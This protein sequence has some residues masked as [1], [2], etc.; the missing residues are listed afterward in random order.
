MPRLHLND[1]RSSSRRRTAKKSRSKMPSKGF[2]AND[3]NQR[4][5]PKPAVESDVK[6]SSTK[7][8]V[9]ILRS[10]RFGIGMQRQEKTEQ[11]G[12]D[13][14]Y[15][16]A[17]KQ[18]SLQENTNDGNDSVHSDSSVDEIN[19]RQPSSQKRN[20][21]NKKKESELAALKNQYET[22]IATMK[23]PN[24]LFSTA[25]QN[26]DDD[27]STGSQNISW[28]KKSALG[29]AHLSAKPGLLSPSEMSRVSTIPPTP[30]STKSNNPVPTPFSEIATTKLH[31]TID[32]TET[33]SQHEIVNEA[34][35]ED[36]V[37]VGATESSTD[38]I[39]ANDNDDLFPGEVDDNGSE[40]ETHRSVS[41]DHAGTLL[42]TPPKVVHTPPPPM[43]KSVEEMLQKTATNDKS[44]IQEINTPGAESAGSTD[45][46]GYSDGNNDDDDVDGGG[47]ELAASNDEEI[48]TN[49]FHDVSEKD[50]I[51]TYSSDNYIEK[52]GSDMTN[53]TVSKKKA[54]TKIEKKSQTMELVT[55]DDKNGQSKRSRKKVRIATTKFRQGYPAGNR[56]YRAI[57]VTNYENENN[58]EDTDNL[59]RSKRRKFPPLDFWRNERVIY[60]ANN[61]IG[62]LGEALGNM[63]VVSSVL[64]AEPTPY[65]KRKVVRLEEASGDRS[66]KVKGQEST[67][68]EEKTIESLKPFN[69]SKLR[70]KFKIQEGKV[71]S[72]WDEG[73]GQIE[74]RKIFCYPED[75]IGHE[76]PH[77]KRNKGES[78]VFGLAAQAF[79]ISADF[80]TLM[81]GYITGNLVLPPKGIKDAE[82][83][84]LCAQV[85]NI[86]DCQPK[87]VEVSIADPAIN[88]G[89]YESKSAQRYFLSKG[90]MFHV[91]PGNIYRIENHSKKSECTLYWTIIRPMK[92]QRPE[93]T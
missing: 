76:L 3:K 77:I 63:P 25:S 5:L 67:L 69:I 37:Q 4:S 29:K 50:D 52:E 60:E 40:Y 92:H 43:E 20:I 15:W 53:K 79:N 89:K 78:K 1:D 86:G 72:V 13:A 32:T 10:K 7:E 47:F 49:S 90:A 75:L 14:A 68:V 85:F 46:F 57:P 23:S 59:R 64:T 56:D 55:P 73:R 35:S 2:E 58:D 16:Q 82:G 74:E 87:S 21:A 44:P 61:E 71:A 84:G 27:E 91:P 66:K 45:Y 65:K 28:I 51:S 34:F 80:S 19:E 22:D 88:D 48:A 39:D 70:K 18:A 33:P 36:K 17:A 31:N 38:F 9:S 41:L 83:V 62:V 93:E 54:K 81:P 30:A 24:F 12:D 11:F 26:R 6:G 8:P 42:P